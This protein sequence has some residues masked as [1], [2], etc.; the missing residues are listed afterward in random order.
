MGSLKGVQATPPGPISIVTVLLWSLI[1]VVVIVDESAVYWEYV[2][3]T[4]VSV[5]T[6]EDP[7][8]I[9]ELVRTVPPDGSATEELA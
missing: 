2:V 7:L 3:G 5:I 6:V 4:K 9:V 8:I 1:D